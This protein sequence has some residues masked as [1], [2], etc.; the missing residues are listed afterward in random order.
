M[1]KEWTE[2][3]DR[4]VNSNST[5]LESTNIIKKHYKKTDQ[6]QYVDCMNKKLKSI[7]HLESGCLILT[8][9]ERYDKIEHYIHWKVCKYF[10]ILDY[11]K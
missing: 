4:G 10:G 5:R 8:P 11:E 2:G 6:I 9:I 3:G 1:A 7:D